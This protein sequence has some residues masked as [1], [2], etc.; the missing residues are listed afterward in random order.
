MRHAA[1]KQIFRSS[2]GRWHGSAGDVE[3]CPF[4]ERGEKRKQEAVEEETEEELDERTQTEKREGEGERACK[5]RRIEGSREA[6]TPT[7]VNE[8]EM[9]EE[10]G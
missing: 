4:C 6:P 10:F 2:F 7:H 9:E 5:E 8:V 3:G 1:A